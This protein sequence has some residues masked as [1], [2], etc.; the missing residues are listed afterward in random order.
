MG[1]TQDSP[2]MV[3]SADVCKVLSKTNPRKAASPDNIPGRALRVCSSELADV[4]G[5]IF[6]LSLAQA[7]VPTCFKS[8]T[9][10]PI[11][12]KSN[13]TCL[14][15]YCP[16]ALTPIT[17]KWNEVMTHIKKNIPDTVDPLQF[18]YCQN[19]CTD[20]AVNTAICTTLS[21]LEGQDTECYSYTIA[22]HLTQLFPTNSQTSS[23]HLD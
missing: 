8:T 22:L 19:Q 12:K 5:D 6:N 17:M 2:L 13:V 4:L 23:S 14:N 7:S 11:P 1:S 21:H 18:A 16:I 9:I 20:D 15:D 3:T 10:V